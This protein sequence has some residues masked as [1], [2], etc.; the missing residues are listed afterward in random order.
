GRTSRQRRV[1][2]PVRARTAARRAREPP[3]GRTS[4]QRREGRPVNFRP[5]FLVP[6]YN[7][8]HTIGRVVERLAAFDLPIYLIDD[9]SDAPTR[10]ALA[11]TVAACPLAR[12]ITLPVNGGKG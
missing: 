5:C 8:P 11:Q 3:S 4:R 6:V 12:L 7:H 1:G 10:K 2:R 9:G